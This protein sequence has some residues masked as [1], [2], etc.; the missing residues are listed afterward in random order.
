MLSCDERCDSI[1]GTPSSADEGTFYSRQTTPA[2][3]GLFGQ[4]SRNL[5]ENPASRWAGGL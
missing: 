4:V 5:V 3:E 1:G 2:D